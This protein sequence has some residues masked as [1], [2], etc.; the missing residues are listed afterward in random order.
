MSNKICSL[1]NEPIPE[2]AEDH[3]MDNCA[4]NLKDRVIK[5]EE[6]LSEYADYENWVSATGPM[7]SE[8]S[9]WCGKGKGWEIA[10]AQGVVL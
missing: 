2:W 4:H 6:A 8:L 3:G 5:L 9:G 7:G 10:Q 1:C